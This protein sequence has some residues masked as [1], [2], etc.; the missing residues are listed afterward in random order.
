MADNFGLKIALEGQKE[1]KSGLREIDQSLRVL[2][3]EMKLVAAQ[4]DQN[5]KSMEAYT[6][7]SQVLT[8]Q[9]DGKKSA[10]A[11]M[12]QAL[13]HASATW[14]ENSTQ[15][16]QWQIKLNKAQA[17]L[18]GLE[19]ELGATNKALD[20]MQEKTEQADKTTD[21]ANATFGELGDLLKGNVAQSI[22]SV[23]IGM[24]DTAK[25]VVDGAKSMGGSIIQ[26]AKDTASGENTVK[27]LGNALRERLEA[28]LHKSAQ[29]M[30]K[31]ADGAENLA[32]EV[33][34]AGDVANS[35]GGQFDSLGDTLKTVGA[36]LAG[37]IAGIG[38]TACAAGALLYNLAT[39][40]AEAGNAV[41]QYSNK[42][43]LSRD[44][45]QEWDYILTQN[46]ASL[47]N[48]QYG[49]RRVTGAMGSTEE[50]GG[51]VGEAITRL[52]L[53]FDQVR[54]KSPEDAM[55]AIVTAFQSMEE[56]ADKTAL[57]L[58]IFGQRGGLE[59]MPLLN[60]T[61]EATDG[62]R[63]RAHELG[64]VMG[65]EAIDAAQAFNNSMDTLERT[66]G[67][68]KH[69]IGAQLLP[70]F[71]SILDGF[72]GLISGCEDAGEAITAGVGEL[73]EGISTAIPQ[74][75]ELFEDVAS[76]VIEIAPELITAL[77]DGIVNNIPQLLE[78]ALGIV[79]ALLSGI[80]DA[81][82]VLLDG[83][84]QIVMTL[85]RGLG[86]ALPTLIPAI[87]DVVLQ[88]VQTLIQNLPMLIDA[89]IQLV[90]GLARGIIEA[91]PLIV[92]AI[93]TMIDSLIDAILGSI[94]LLISA[95]IELFIALV[96]AAPQIIAGIVMALPQIISGI[97]RGI[98]DLVP[99]LVQAGA[100]LLRG[101]IDGMLGMATAAIDAIRDIGGRILGAVRG[102][103]GINSPSTVMAGVG[104]NLAEGIAVG[105]ED[106]ARHTQRTMTDSMARAGDAAA[107]GAVNAVSSG[108]ANQSGQLIAAGQ[109][110]THRVADGTLQGTGSVAGAAPH[111]AA[112]YAN[113][114]AAEHATMHMAGADMSRSVAEGI[115]YAA[116][117]VVAAATSVVDGAMGAINVL[118]RAVTELFDLTTRAADA[119]NAVTLMSQQLGLSA[120][121][122]Q[123]WDFVLTR[124]GSSVGSLADGM[125][126][127]RDSF[128]DVDNE[129][130]EVGRTLT[131]LGLDF[132]LLRMKSPDDAL[133]AVVLAFQGMEN[134]A[135]KAAMA[136]QIF[137]QRSA[138]ELLPLLNST[139]EA[140]DQLRQQAHDLGIVLGDDVLDNAAAFT[141]N[142]NTLR[143]AVGGVKNAI[144]AELLPGFAGVMDGFVALLAGSDGAG[145]KISQG[146]NDLV[147][148]IA[149]ALPR[150][151]SVF[152]GLITAMADIAPNIIITLLDGILQ[153]L[154]MLV[155][156]A[157]QIVTSL[158][159]G[160]A[161]A[162]PVLL[163]AVVEV[164]LNLVLMLVQQIP[165]IIDAALQL[166]I[167][168]AQG[169]L[170]AIP[171]LIQA[172][173]T[174]VHA[175]V[176]ALLASIP[177]IILAGVQL[178]T[179]II[180]DL[181]TIIVEI[182]AALPQLIA[183]II[184]ALIGAVPQFMQAGV[185]MITGLIGGVQSMAQNAVD[186]V[187]GVGQRIVSGVRGFFGINSPS[188]V[189]ASIGKSLA[190]GIGEGFAGQAGNMAKQLQD[191]LSAVP[192]TMNVQSLHAA[193]QGLLMPAHGQL[194]PRAGGGFHVTQHIYANETSYA[195]Q[196]REAALNYKLL[197][198]EVG[199]L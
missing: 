76:V 187:R 69:G 173:P 32:D 2:G 55:N 196:Q 192:Y 177:L 115:Q 149:T 151:L 57:S 117:Q 8:K 166:I 171:V 97:V 134:S 182:V 1:F 74:L 118:R 99:M 81:L 188:T 126:I 108:V 62:L 143:H 94:P 60:S 39:G 100:D 40:A 131:R 110:M 20:L 148:G 147:Q 152:Q 156:G 48:F 109:S 101:L 106:E 73:V 169:L 77:V 194:E 13:A 43:G 38:A 31:A 6:A 180:A 105:F 67:G 141:N 47:Y 12:E 78:A 16:A 72:T 116:S 123:E 162:V 22:D 146:A 155:D 183:A 139:A 161:V 132:D 63:Q 30:D 53:D 172:V 71:A 170:Q 119:G 80:L 90:M 102:F 19:K 85:A 184:S 64:M 158:A 195:T 137:G 41:A 136:A 9:V 84:L 42:L 3:S 120:Q 26:F 45:V 27:A 153:T 159:H 95:G 75:L 92:A 140:T 24:I 87:V 36:T 175:I 33:Q 128:A 88:I 133:H 124:H 186:A 49:L 122:V 142:L 144:A 50:G 59:L 10:I 65:D 179:A 21:R 150:V 111:I 112:A 79:M 104:R 83:A 44:A 35:A 28:A 163:P 113:A 178:L 86:D 129:G 66:F 176:E 58:Q 98:I 197:A 121:A 82:P 15:A 191:T 164:V 46:G 25:G 181:P 174:L 125:N 56:G 114:L 52:G 34:G 103:F 68:V 4:F 154:P 127:L 61:A 11:L 91:I 185:Q 23:K 17:E 135:E 18:I 29:G 54:K 157:L 14:G 193:A 93:P 89:A 51:K 160:L 198:R 190:E 138:T 165:L 5:D 189:F 96:A 130:G 199:A 7:R 70:G 145:R 168:L 107:R 37:T 167:G